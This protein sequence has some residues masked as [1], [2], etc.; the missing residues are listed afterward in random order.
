MQSE[1]STYYN[2]E[3]GINV[4]CGPMFAGKTSRLVADFDSADPKYTLAIRPHHDTRFEDLSTHSGF[5]VPSITVRN[6]KDFEKIKNSSF[7]FL[8]IDEIHFFNNQFFDGDIIT[9]LTDL[10]KTKN[11]HVYG[12]NTDW[13]GE[14]FFVTSELI[15][16]AKKVDILSG[17]CFNCTSASSRTIRK[18]AGNGIYDVGASDMYLPACSVCANL[19]GAHLKELQCVA[20][21]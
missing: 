2:S 4:I 12:L 16:I 5:S 21:P 1:T 7:N 17:T 6:T 9:I 18:S 3:I 20:L 14:E 10:S 11:I 15:K 13:R 19:F 8:L